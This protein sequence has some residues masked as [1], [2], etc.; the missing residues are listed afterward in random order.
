MLLG[1]PPFQQGLTIL[2]FRLFN[3]CSIIII[4]PIDCS[5]LLQKVGCDRVLGS[6][7]VPDM[8]GVCNGDNS[9]CKV[10]RGQYTKQHYGNRTSPRP[11]QPG[12]TPYRTHA[13]KR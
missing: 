5:S 6:K 8:C 2:L 11:L 1:N 12:I 3:Q 13:H 4:I 7:A 9:T 10:Y